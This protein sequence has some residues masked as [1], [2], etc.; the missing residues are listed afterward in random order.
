[1]KVIKHIFVDLEN[2]G[3]KGIL[4]KSSSIGLDRDIKLHILYTKFATHIELDTLRTITKC[5]IDLVKTPAGDQSL[6]KHLIAYLSALVGKLVG[7]N[8]K[9]KNKK[10][11]T[12]AIVSNDK[13][14]DSICEL[15]Q[16]QFNIECNRYSNVEQAICEARH[17]EKIIE[18]A[19]EAS[20]VQS[21]KS[22][23]DDVDVLSENEDALT[24]KEYSGDVEAE[25]FI[26][27]T[28][29]SEPSNENWFTGV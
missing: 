24:E 19:N 25:A 2:V 6:D 16:T 11:E 22:L 3:N 1:M 17:R 28:S 18:A 13:G 23:I 27:E 10:Q 9:A 12:F 29:S 14:Y 26:E 8:A 5:D 7:L 4:V 21:K 20:V 15:L